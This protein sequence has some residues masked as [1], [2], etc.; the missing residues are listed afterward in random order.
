MKESAYLMKH[1]GGLGGQQADYL[2]EEGRVCL[3]RTLVFSPE[4]YFKNPC[5]VD[6]TVAKEEVK[7]YPQYIQVM[8][9]GIK[10]RKL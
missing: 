10:L 2:F 7:T 3:L 1:L 6:E 9:S 4:D 8:S 5:W